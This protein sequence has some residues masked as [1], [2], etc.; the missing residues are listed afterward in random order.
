[1]Q[2]TTEPSK[3]SRTDGNTNTVFEAASQESAK[4]FTMLGNPQSTICPLYLELTIQQKTT[5]Q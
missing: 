3:M 4:V 2:A 1:M 5:Q